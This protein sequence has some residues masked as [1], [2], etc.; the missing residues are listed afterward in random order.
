MRWRKPRQPPACRRRP[1]VGRRQRLAQ[2][3][4]DRGE[5]APRSPRPPAGGIST[6]ASSRRPPVRAPPSPSRA[7]RSSAAK[8]HLLVTFTS[9]SRTQSVLY[10]IGYRRDCAPR[11]LL[12][13]TVM[14][15][16]AKGS[17]RPVH[18]VSGTWPATPVYGSPLV[19]AARRSLAAAADA[20]VRS[21]P[22]VRQRGPWAR[23]S[24]SP[25]RRC[26]ARSRRSI[27]AISSGVAP[28]GASN[29]RR[30]VAG[31]RVGRA[32]RGR[33]ASPRGRA[34]AGLDHGRRAL[35]AGEARAEVADAVAGGLAVAALRHPLPRAGARR[36]V[37]EALRRP[38]GMGDRGRRVSLIACPAPVRTF[39]SFFGAAGG[40]GRSCWSGTATPGSSRTGTSGVLRSTRLDRA[41]ARRPPPRRVTACWRCCP[42]SSR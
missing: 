25:S 38:L 41:C 42:R 11:L 30:P 39:P 29:V 2:L 21:S 15:I 35:R 23:A 32:R 24:R 10:P 36:L 18:V 14:S 12:T 40:E 1:P 9:P 16:H 3:A 20:A 33:R 5:L 8:L 19:A 31:R 4:F 22:A 37:P 17:G 6:R 26:R 28:S 27:C 7:R 34:R 13:F